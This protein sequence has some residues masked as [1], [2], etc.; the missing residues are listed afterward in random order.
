M[1][2]ERPTLS[3]KDFIRAFVKFLKKEG[4]FGEFISEKRASVLRG[5]EPRWISD[6]ML[7]SFN[8]A[9][10]ICAIGSSFLWGATK[11]GEMR[12][13]KLSLKWSEYFCLEKYKQWER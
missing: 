9:N 3:H 6:P 12:W 8:A 5:N 10:Q 7:S 11:R 2:K 4:A 1:S 13:Y